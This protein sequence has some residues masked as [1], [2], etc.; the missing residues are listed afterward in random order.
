MF[1]MQVLYQGLYTFF[2][3]FL[4]QFVYDSAYLFIL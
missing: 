4:E 1:L 2:F 3:Y